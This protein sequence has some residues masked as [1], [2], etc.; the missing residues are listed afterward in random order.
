MCLLLLFDWLGKTVLLF[1]HLIQKNGM[2][3]AVIST[4]GGIFLVTVTAAGLLRFSKN[5][6][7]EYYCY[8][9]QRGGKGIAVVLYLVYGMYFVLQTLVLLR[10]C[11]EI[12][13]RYLLPETDVRVLMLLVL[14]VSFFMVGGGLEVRARLSELLCGIVAVLLALMLGSGLLQAHWEA[15]WHQEQWNGMELVKNSY[16]AAAGFGSIFTLPFVVPEIEKEHRWEKNVYAALFVNGALLLLV[17]LAGFG[18]LGDTG[19]TRM[20]WP[21]IELMSSIKLPGMFLQRWDLIFVGVLLFS[22][23]FAVGSG[24]YYMETLWF[25]LKGGREKNGKTLEGCSGWKRRRIGKKKR[26]LRSMIVLLLFGIVCIEGRWEVI[27]QW[28]H[29]LG[30]YICVPVIAAITI[31]TGIREWQQNK[32]ERKQTGQE[33]VQK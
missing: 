3:N 23:I 2:Y 15:A 19:M 20:E 16:A 24:I 18:I 25:A 14:A 17:Y 21:L 30:L 33:Y 5:I 6:D 13:G 22:L 11:G 32:E 7:G 31:L 8:V 9:E 4:V 29:R 1:P 10:L 28:Y 27:F 12:T 26:L